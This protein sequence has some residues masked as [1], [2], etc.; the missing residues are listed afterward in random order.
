MTGE[1]VISSQGVA[2]RKIEN[3]L[4]VYAFVTFV[5]QV[6]MAVCM[7]NIY[8]S[9]NIFSNFLFFATYNQTPLVNVGSSGV[10]F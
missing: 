6:L 4:T 2:E 5:A 7:I 9:I 8:I 1:V 10:C 3:R